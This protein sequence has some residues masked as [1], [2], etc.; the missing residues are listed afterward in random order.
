MKFKSYAKINL[1]LDVINKREDGYHNL[2][3][4]MHS[5]ALCDD[6]DITINESGK[7]TV[8]TNLRYLPNNKKNH[9]YRAAE[10]FFAET[11]ITNPGIHIN[12]FKR[13]PVSAGL[14]GGSSNAAAVLKGLNKIFKAGLTTAH[15]AKTGLRIGADVPYCI[16]GGTML[17]EGI[18]EILTPLPAL[19][20]APVVL[21]KPGINI[22]T[23]KVFSEIAADKIKLHPDT[24]GMISALNDADINGVCKRMYNVLEPAAKT[25]MA[26]SG[27]AHAIEEL[28]EIF[29][30]HGAAGT[31]MSGSGPTVF[32]VFDDPKKAKSAYY[33]A[34]TITKDAFL[35]ST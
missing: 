27:M 30:K 12:I 4:I 6:I 15:L 16:Y 35:T 25:V 17:A 9:A 1:S 2:K 29:S 14:G 13:I 20:K 18:G 24:D 26:K 28:K 11:G 10:L 19:P 32:A 31:L 22:S 33:E 7:I 8:S 5:V 21:A 34:R 23:P 3:M